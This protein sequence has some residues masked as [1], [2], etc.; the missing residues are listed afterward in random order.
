M[1]V[2]ETAL[3]SA[4][5][6]RVEAGQSRTGVPR[7]GAQCVVVLEGEG[8]FRTADGERRV[9]VHSVVIHSAARAWELIAS[10]TTTLIVVHWS[11]EGLQ[12][13]GHLAVGL[14]A[15]VALMGRST[16]ALAWRLRAELRRGDE[17]SDDAVE[18]FAR[19]I[20]LSLSRFQRRPRTR[21]R[22]MARRARA[23]IA[24]MT[25]AVPPMAEL[26]NTLGI[27]PAYLSRVFR[28]A[29]GE[30]PSA[31]ARRQRVERAAH[32]LVTTQR[33]VGWIAHAMGYADASHFARDFTRSN[34]LSPAAYRRQ[35]GQS[36]GQSDTVPS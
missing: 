17:F 34:E 20:A 24:V 14:S 10:E 27:S 19:A 35:Y 31:F 18:L 25:P 26:A 3:V 1:V 22:M 23:M 32:L 2:K 5:E 6:Y 8:R 15:D 13:L 28:S 33:T 12:R 30:S 4:V 21:E 16:P 11:P 9:A 7:A 29:Y 36:K